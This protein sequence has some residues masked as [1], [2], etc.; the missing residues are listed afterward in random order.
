MTINA[1]TSQPVWRIPINN[2]WSRLCF[3]YSTNFLCQLEDIKVNEKSLAELLQE[4]NHDL[5]SVLANE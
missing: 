1:P 3:I 5:E 4:T 2:Q